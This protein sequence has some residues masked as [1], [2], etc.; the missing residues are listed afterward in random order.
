MNNS[1]TDKENTSLLVQNNNNNNKADEDWVVDTVVSCAQSVN[2][3]FVRNTCRLCQIY[4]DRQVSFEEE[5]EKM[6]C[7]DSSSS[8]SSNPVERA[9]LK[10]TPFI[11]APQVELYR[12]FL[13]DED[14]VVDSVGL[15][16]TSPTAQT[17]EAPVPA[18]VEDE[19]SST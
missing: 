17:T 9:F 12:Q 16:T 3:L 14:S 13:F 4:V 8:S 10:A 2:K 6:M 15:R 7:S 5:T 11:Q 1:E 18:E 19:R